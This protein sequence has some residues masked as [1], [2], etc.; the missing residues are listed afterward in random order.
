M[1]ADHQ[2][3]LPEGMS[4]AHL[5]HAGAESEDAV[6]HRRHREPSLGAE[7]RGLLSRSEAQAR[8]PVRDPDGAG[9]GAHPVIAA[10]LPWRDASVASM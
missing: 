6:A 2:Q 5:Q 9:A 1:S 10:P 8:P 7:Y 3:P 4:A